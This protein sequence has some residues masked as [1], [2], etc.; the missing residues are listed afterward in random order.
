LRCDRGPSDPAAERGHG[1]HHEFG[2]VG[3]KGDD[4]VVLGGLG[5]NRLRV[6]NRSALRRVLGETP[7]AA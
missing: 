1:F 3:R 2:I 4:P 6:L 7:V 5:R